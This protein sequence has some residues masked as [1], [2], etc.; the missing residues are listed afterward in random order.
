MRD[1]VHLGDARLANRAAKS[2]LPRKLVV[3]NGLTAAEQV[4]LWLNHNSAPVTT[5]RTAE[6]S[7]ASY[8]RFASMLLA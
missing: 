3:E 7:N 1:V 2:D 6:S 4:V 5:V 8:E